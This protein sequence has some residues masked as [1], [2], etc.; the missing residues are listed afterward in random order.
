MIPPTSIDGTD[1]T[2]ATIDGTDVQEIT[3]DGDVVFSSGP[4]TIVNG[5]ETPSEWSVTNDVGTGSGIITSNEARSGSKTLS[6][7][8]IGGQPDGNNL[9]AT[10][11]S[12][13]FTSAEITHYYKPG[14]SN[15]WNTAGIFREQ[16]PGGDAI[17][18]YFDIS[19]GSGTFEIAEKTG[20]S[21]SKLDDVACSETITSGAYN[22]VVIGLTGDG[23]NVSGYGIVNGT[24]FTTNTV[25]TSITS[26]GTFGIGQITPSNTGASNYWDDITISFD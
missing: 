4:A 8:G 5:F 22:E 10:F 21:F 14:P 20:T 18:V 2:G 6:A 25:T 7:N 15:F 24:T 3:V 12:T 16:S 9:Y 1:I 17:A 11:D 26:K 13:T 19:F 23:T